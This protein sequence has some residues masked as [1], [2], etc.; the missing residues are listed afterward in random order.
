M[1]GVT[2]LYVLQKRFM[3]PSGNHALLAGGARCLQGAVGAGLRRISSEVEAIALSLVRDERQCLAGRADV[4]VVIADLAKVRLAELPID[5]HARCHRLGQRDG[6]VSL[7][8]ALGQR[9]DA[10]VVFAL[11]YWVPRAAAR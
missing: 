6:D 3:L 11:A 10:S 9:M 5:L 7:A 2:P 1:S 8:A 4:D